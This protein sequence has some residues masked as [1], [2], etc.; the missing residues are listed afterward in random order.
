MSSPVSCRRISSRRLRTCTESAVFLNSSQLLLSAFC[1][2][3]SYSAKATFCRTHAQQS[4]CVSAFGLSMQHSGTKSLP[5]TQ[6]PFAA[7]MHS[8]DLMFSVS[9][10][11]QY[12]SMRFCRVSLSTV[13]H[14]I[15]HFQFW[16]PLQIP[17]RPVNNAHLLRVFS[18]FKISVHSFCSFLLLCS[19][20]QACVA[21]FL[22]NLPR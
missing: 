7:A 12:I 16:E 5:N 19:V 22:C 18:A 8:A 11:L 6:D 15:K 4:S 13:R 21:H 2:L 9:S 17:V 14:M 10:L 20:H 3:Q 1:H